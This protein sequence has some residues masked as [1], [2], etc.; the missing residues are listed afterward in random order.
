VA[1]RC[2]LTLDSQ[3]RAT[4]TLILSEDPLDMG[5]GA[6]ASTLAHQFEYNNPGNQ[7]A[8][9]T[10]NVKFALNHPE[11]A[12]GTTNFGGPDIP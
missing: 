2:S 12:G 5:F 8:Q 1:L 10:F 3:G 4:D 9:L 6:A 11:P 7:P